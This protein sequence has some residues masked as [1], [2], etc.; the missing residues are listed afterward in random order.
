MV[1]GKLADLAR[2][3]HA[4][5]GQQDLRLADA[6]GIEDD[7]AG[8]G[9]ARVVLVADAEI[10]VAERHPNA[11]AAPAYMDDVALE[12]KGLAERCDGLWRRLFLEPGVE[13]EIAGADHEFAHVISL[14]R[15]GAA[16]QGKHGSKSTL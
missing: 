2:E 12:R 4:A 14:R 3:M 9:I 1:A 16:L 10:E 11:L 8:R 15:R 6:A 5:I 13:G 7:L